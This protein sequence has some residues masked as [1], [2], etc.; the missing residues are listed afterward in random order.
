[1]E[2]NGY[3]INF[4]KT[5]LKIESWIKNL[6]SNVN[7]EKKIIQKVLPD[8]IISDIS[9]VPFLVAKKYQIP[10][11][12]IS[13][14]TWYEVLS[15][16]SK[17]LKQILKSSYEKADYAIQLPLGTEMSLFIKKNKVGIVCK[18]PTS[19]RKE[20]RKKLGILDSE[21]CVFVNLGKFYNFKWNIEKNIKIISTGAKINSKNV[22][23][24]QP[25]TEG[26]DLILA[27]DLVICKCGYGMITECISNGTKFYYLIDKK[28]IEQ[29][30]ISN[31]LE[32]KGIFCKISEKELNSLQLTNDFIL[33][34]KL[35]KEKIDTINVVSKILDFLN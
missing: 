26:Q 33:S 25:W 15:N 8:L 30:A 28:H 23:Y 19:S 16:I 6:N 31:E 13:N 1:M 11:I 27:A 2:N 17:E 4:E 29:K 24:I 35:K 12:A 7:A 32:K 5:N 18:K 21:L 10:S 3:V 22:I 9:I 34:K 20:I 14:F